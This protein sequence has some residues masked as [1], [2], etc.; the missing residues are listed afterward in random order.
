MDEFIKAFKCF[1]YKFK[2]VLIVIDSIKK[3]EDAIIDNNYMNEFVKQ[4][5]KK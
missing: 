2:S 3:S 1:D 4:L 5:K